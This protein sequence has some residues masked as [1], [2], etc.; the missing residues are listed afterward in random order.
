MRFF[1]D[2]RAVTTGEDHCFHEFISIPF[3][4]RTF[5]KVLLQTALFENAVF[6]TGI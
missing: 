1:T 4:L 5:L 6:K 2:A 3:S